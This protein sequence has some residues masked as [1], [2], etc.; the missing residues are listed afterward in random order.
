[1]YA[2]DAGT[3]SEPDSALHTDTSRVCR[4]VRRRRWR[5]SV[6]IGSIIGQ[7]GSPVDVAPSTLAIRRSELPTRRSLFAET[8]TICDP[9]SGDRA[10][11]RMGRATPYDTR[12]AAGVQ[13]YFTGI[14]VNA[15]VNVAR[16]EFDTLKAV[17]TDGVRPGAARQHHEGVPILVRTSVNVSHR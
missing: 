3:S 8:G 15:E 10:G 13:H 7:P 14:V 11:C 12:L 2:D 17:L 5:T 9:D 16:G 6:Q 4:T 1:M